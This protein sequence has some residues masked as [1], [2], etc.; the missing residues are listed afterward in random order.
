MPNKF[1]SG[2]IMFCHAIKKISWTVFYAY[3]LNS[4]H[5]YVNRTASNNLFECAD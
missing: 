4:S 3:L 2:F 5:L 1:V